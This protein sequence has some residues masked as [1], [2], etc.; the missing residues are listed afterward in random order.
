MVGRKADKLRRILSVSVVRCSQGRGAV[1]GHL[2]SI[3]TRGCWIPLRIASSDHNFDCEVENMR[4][5]R[6]YGSAVGRIGRARQHNAGEGAASQGQASDLDPD[7]V[8]AG[9]NRDI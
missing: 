7:F 8:V 2:N 9:V 3:A 4:G 5:G 6:H 1:Y